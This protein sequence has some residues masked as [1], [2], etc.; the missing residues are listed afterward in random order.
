M[1]YGWS[2]LVLVAILYAVGECLVAVYTWWRTLDIRF[3]RSAEE[4]QRHFAQARNQLM[5]SAVTG[6]LSVDSPVFK[7]FYAIN[8]ALMRRPDQYEEI[9]KA[10][11]PVLVLEKTP[12]NAEAFRNEMQKLSPE[13]LNAVRATADALGHLVVDYSFLLRNAFRLFRHSNPDLTQMEWIVELR[14]AASPRRKSDLEDQID[15]AQ[16]DI[17]RLMPERHRP[18]MP[19]HAVPA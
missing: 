19:P 15:R 5:E 12:G 2:L 18:S 16:K 13:A 9:S 6:E 4:T 1:E 17:Y 3:R 11:A 10:I 14:D 8:T 7:L